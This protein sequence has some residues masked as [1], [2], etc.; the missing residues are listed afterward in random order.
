M[1]SVEELVKL[2]EK[3]GETLAEEL[4]PVFNEAF[5]QMSGRYANASLGVDEITMEK[6]EI[7]QVYVSGVNGNDDIRF[8]FP[9]KYR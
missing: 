7:S 8:D 4:S 5:R 3:D 1:R 9:V 6:G 2:T